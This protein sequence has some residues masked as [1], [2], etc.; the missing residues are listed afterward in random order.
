VA[1]GP[2]L[3]LGELLMAF[4]LGKGRRPEKGADA[5][6][7]KEDPAYW[8]RVKAGDFVSLSDLEAFE[9]SLRPAGGLAGGAAGAGSKDGAVDYRVGEV[10]AI[11]LIDREGH[12]LGGGYRFLEL[13]PE[14]PREGSGSLYL[15][16]VDLPELFEL[17]L[18]FIP[19]GLDPGSR[20]EWIDRD[21]SWLF[22]PP[23]DPEDFLSRDL[24]YAPFPDLPEI[25]GRKLAFARSG[26]APLYGEA[27]DTGAPFIVAEYEAEPAEGEAP[28]A[29]PL[30][31]VLEEGWM[32]PDGSR[33]EG[34]GYLTAML[35]KRLRLD[36]VEHWPA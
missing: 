3:A 13:R 30:F 9:E 31:I 4:G 27:V 36:E 28:P 33:P 21:D 32:S 25:D 29:N 22:L 24:E 11:A 12:A 7:G 26:P 34:G 20:D 23:P 5:G 17:R 6:A 19:A 10:R 35:G 2:G 15:A 8:S 18:Y 1:Q 16:V 14:G